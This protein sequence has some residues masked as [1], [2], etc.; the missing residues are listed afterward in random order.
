MSFVDLGNGALSLLRRRLRPLAAYRD[1]P[2]LL[3][4]LLLESFSSLRT[5]LIPSILSI[6]AI[7]NAHTVS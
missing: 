3:D 1:V 5:C 7:E 4:Y 2:I 6:K